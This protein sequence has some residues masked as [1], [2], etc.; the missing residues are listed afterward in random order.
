MPRDDSA[1]LLDML[2]AA[3][4]ALSFT[5]G[6]SYDEFARDRRTQLSVLKS[7][8]IVGEAAAHV[9]EDTQRAH[10]A[11][12]W[13]EIVGMRNRLVHDYFDI[14]LPLVWD[15]VCDDLPVLMG[16]LEPLVPPEAG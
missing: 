1:Y 2:L 6:M 14:D 7:V 10:P 16:R 15:T 11:I 5:E 4:D 9:G 3:R 13:R 8:E 12:P